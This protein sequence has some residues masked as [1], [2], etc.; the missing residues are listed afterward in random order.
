VI[1]LSFT[2]P[3]TKK[4]S[5]GNDLLSQRAP[6][7]VPSALAGLTAGFGMDPGVPPPLQSPRDFFSL[8][9]LFSTELDENSKFSAPLR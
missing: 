6:P 5:L 2:P 3:T 4:K 9:I 1:L 7:P 8:A